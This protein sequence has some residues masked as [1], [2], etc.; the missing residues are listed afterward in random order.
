MLNKKLQNLFMKR[1]AVILL[2]VISG[3]NLFH[4]REPQTPT[5]TATDTQILFEDSVF[6]NINKGLQQLNPD[7]YINSFTSQFQFNPVDGFA[8][9]ARFVGW[10]RVQE[11]AFIRRLVN[12]LRTPASNR[13][14]G[15][16]GFSSQIDNKQPQG[17]DFLYQVAYRFSIRYAG[18]ASDSNYQ[19]NATVT[20]KQMQGSWGIDSWKDNPIP[21]TTIPT[22]TTLKN[23]N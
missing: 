21:N 20:V 8:V 3:C 12:L 4:T 19:G 1:V 14:I 18:A 13:S 17:G 7:I 5:G 11:D 22:L 15:A 23:L 9:Q 10:G 16:A 6:T 2:L